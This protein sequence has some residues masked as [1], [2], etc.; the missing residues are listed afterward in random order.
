M[1]EILEPGMVVRHKTAPEWGLGQVQSRIG[2]RIT[3]NFTE[4][5]KQVL[6]GNKVSLELIP[7]NGS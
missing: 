1:N 4:A 5:G 7:Q 2:N 3:V 6:D